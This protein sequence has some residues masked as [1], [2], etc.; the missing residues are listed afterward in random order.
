MV[1]NDDFSISIELNNPLFNDNEMFSYP[2][3]FPLD[4]NRHVLKN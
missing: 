4:G 1:L 2:V 3:S